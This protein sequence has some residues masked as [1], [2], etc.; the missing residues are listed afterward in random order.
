MSVCIAVKNW[1][2][3]PAYLPDI[4]SNQCPQLPENITGLSE[5][6]AHPF[7]ALGEYM[8][9]RKQTPLKR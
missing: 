2:R 9:A 8:C 3:I 6:F 1:L 7:P 4:T 5:S